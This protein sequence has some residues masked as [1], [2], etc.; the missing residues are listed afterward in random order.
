MNVPTRLLHYLVKHQIPL[1]TQDH[2]HSRSSVET[3]RAARVPAH[4][5]AK[6]VIVESED[7]QCT[8]AVLPSDR[9]VHLDRLGRLLNRGPLHLAGESR[10]AELFPD[11][12]TGA[13]PAFGTAWNL[14]TVIDD[15]LD[16]AGATLYVECGDHEHLLCL[17]HDQFRALTQDIPRGHFSTARLH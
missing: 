5:L 14:D 16:Q 12:E 4:Q 2:A 11:C 9:Q 13:I 7:R 8:I 3:A 10:L 15:E 17:Q 1:A 6:A